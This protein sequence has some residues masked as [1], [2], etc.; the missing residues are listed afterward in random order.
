MSRTAAKQALIDQL[1]I[2]GRRYIFGNPGTTEQG[3]MDALQDQ[4]QLEFILALHE[5]VAVGVADAYARATHKPAFVELHIAPGL[6]NAMGMLYDAAR[7]HSPLVVYA[8]Q[9]DTRSL[10]QEPLLT[11]DLVRMAEPL[12][13]WSAEVTRGADV[14]MLL[15]RAMKVAADP[16][17]GPVFLSLPLDVLDEVDEM[18]VTPTSYVRSRTRP[19]AE[20]L[21][22]AAGMLAAARS[23]VIVVGDGVAISGAQAEVGELAELLGAPIQAGY[24]SEMNLP[25]AHPLAGN[26]LNVVSGA[27]VRASLDGSDVILIVGTPVFR[28]IFP[29][30]GSPLPEGARVIQIDLDTWELAKNAPVDFALA[31]DPKTTLAEL[32]PLVRGLMS[33]GAQADAQA[34]AAAYVE[35]RQ[36]TEA[37]LRE[38]DDKRRDQVPIAVTRLMEEIAAALPPDA[39]IFDESV[40]SGGALQRYLRLEP[41]GYFRARGGG[42]GP[43]MPGAVG[44]QLAYPERPV[45]GVV[46]DGSAMYTISALWTAAHHNVPVTWVICNNSSYRILKLNLQDYLGEAG[47]TRRFMHTDLVDPPLCY[48]RIAE[49]MGVRGSRVE[50]PEDLQDALREAMAFPGPSLVDVV[51]D[52]AVPGRAR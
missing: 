51:I 14:P 10:A 24:A 43:G 9:S 7:G 40:T 2:D 34:R 4:S 1:T 50:R 5:G 16:P 27:A 26:P 3:F 35:R 46:A 31:A 52:P 37:R 13:K 41:G 6:G 15:R 8:G 45:V 47:A 18:L 39:A 22:Q 21:R 25:A 49:S 20:T 32:V 48:D 11:G 42:L 33:A 12:C 36:A 44:L 19:D 23:P 38:Q 17:P 29:A 30:E 28:T